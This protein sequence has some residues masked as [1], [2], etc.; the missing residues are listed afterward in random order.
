M[1]AAIP[2]GS[3]ELLLAKF[4]TTPMTGRKQKD[5]KLIIDY[6]IAQDLAALAGFFALTCLYAHRVLINFTTQIA[7]TGRDGWQCLWNMWWFKE[8][9]GKG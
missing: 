8:A 4:R 1:V 6:N 9:L 3:S 5:E 2:G 7:G